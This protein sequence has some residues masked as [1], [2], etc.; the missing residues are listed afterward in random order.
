MTDVD[1]RDSNAI[2]E[3]G[4]LAL[5]LGR[6]NRIT[7]HPDGMTLESDTDHTVMLGLVGCA[8]AQ[9]YLP[10]LDLGLIAQYCVVHDLSEVYAG[11]TPTLRITPEERDRK[12]QREKVSR[13]RLRMRFGVTLPWVSQ[14]IDEYE[15]QRTPE[16]RYVKAMDKLVPKITHILN[17][18]VTIREQCMTRAM[19]VQRYEDQLEELMGYAS[20]FPQLFSLR[21]D[22]IAFMFDALDKAN[23]WGREN[24]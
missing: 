4:D 8:F 10:D 7:Y 1:V 17:V 11:D 2:V 16:S 20:D 14:T 3:L 12:H 19:I 21:D 24:E 18:G 6:V 13:G 22:L 9:K 23:G 15:E 5:R